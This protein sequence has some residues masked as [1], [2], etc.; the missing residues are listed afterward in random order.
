MPRLGT[1]LVE[2]IT[3]SHP[4]VHRAVEHTFLSEICIGLTSRQR[5]ISINAILAARCF[6]S[7]KLKKASHNKFFVTDKIPQNFFYIALIF[8]LFLEA[9]VIHVKRDAAA[10]CW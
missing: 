8:K 4:Q 9:K 5:D 1:T 6:Y 7:E 3:S 2:Q 10:T